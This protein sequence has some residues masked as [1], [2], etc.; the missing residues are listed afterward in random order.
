[1]VSGTGD[2]SGL[3][4]V[5]FASDCQRDRPPGDWDIGFVALKGSFK[6]SLKRALQGFFKGFEAFYRGS[7]L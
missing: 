4:P 2:I 3:S 1:M 7:L 5:T 6:G